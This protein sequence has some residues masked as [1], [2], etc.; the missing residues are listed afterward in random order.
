M[1]RATLIVLALAACATSS[2]IT[3]ALVGSWGG[4]HAQLMVGELD[5]AIEF[6]CAEGTVFGPYLVGRDNNFD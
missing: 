5:S 1:S 3:P 4:D 6:D 2:N